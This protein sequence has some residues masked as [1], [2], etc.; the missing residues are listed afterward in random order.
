MN[1]FIELITYYKKKGLLE[2]IHRIKSRYLSITKFIIYK[3]DLD[4]NYNGIELGPEYKVIIDD[5]NVLNELRIKRSD[6]PREFYIDKT[7]AGRHFYLV[8]KGNEV[9][10]IHWVLL[11][12]DYSRFFNLK[13]GKTAE[14]N[15]NITLPE[16]RGDKLMSKTINFICNDLK[17]KGYKT[18]VGAV[19]EGNILSHKSLRKTGFR[20]DCK[21]LSVFSISK[22]KIV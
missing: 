4:E 19:S 15:Y 21:I 22:K 5:F 20:E 9:A 12:D 17:G 16:F 18:L 3:R 2:T 1:K 6:L 8:F 10:Y 7:H 14:L 11:K 13:D